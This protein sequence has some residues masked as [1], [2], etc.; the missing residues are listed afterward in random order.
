MCLAHL[1]RSQGYKKARIIHCHLQ[2]ATT[3]DTDLSMLM[4]PGNSGQNSEVYTVWNPGC[5]WKTKSHI[6]DSRKFRRRNGD[7]LLLPRKKTEN[8]EGMF[9]QF[10]FQKFTALDFPEPKVGEVP[11]TDIKDNKFYYGLA[12][13]C[14][15]FFSFSS[16]YPCSHLC[17]REESG[18][19]KIQGAGLFCS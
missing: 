14:F 2:F 5:T 12:F 7:Q 16:N 4:E 13:F 18:L 3:S 11:E 8:W 1:L 6:T 15:D 9:S 17:R 10:S 19:L